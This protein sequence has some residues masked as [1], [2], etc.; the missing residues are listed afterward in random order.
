MTVKLG[1]IMVQLPQGNATG[2]DQVVA[3]FSVLLENLHVVPQESQTGAELGGSR[4]AHSPLT[5]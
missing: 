4:G 3:L 1:E 2:F 5:G